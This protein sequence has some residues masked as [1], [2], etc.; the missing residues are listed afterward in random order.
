MI[1]FLYVTT[2]NKDEAQFIGRQLLEERIAACVNIIEGMTSMY[3]WDGKIEDSKEAILIVKTDDAYNEKAILRI[4]ELHSYDCPCI[5]VLPVKTGNKA[6]MDWLNKQLG[7][8][9]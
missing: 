4:S 2:G 1:N 6:Y 7:S 5:L 9:L 8:E 3:W